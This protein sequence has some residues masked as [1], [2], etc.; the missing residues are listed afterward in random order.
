MIRAMCDTS[1]RLSHVWEDHME[2]I[3]TDRP[4]WEIGY[5]GR[6]SAKICWVSSP[7]CSVCNVV[8]LS[9][10]TLMTLL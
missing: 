3:L 6:Y 5:M 4:I 8:E 2:I 9:L 1:N 7:P 10:N